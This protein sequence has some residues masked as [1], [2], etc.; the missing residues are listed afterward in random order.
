MKEN[1]EVVN[2]RREMLQM[3]IEKINDAKYERL[4]SEVSGY[5][6]PVLR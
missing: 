1:C 2:D 4:P 3:G 5:D 6:D